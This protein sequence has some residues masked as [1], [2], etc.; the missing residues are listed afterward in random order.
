MAHSDDLDFVQ[1][2]LAGSRMKLILYLI[3]PQA[4]V[5]SKV[6]WIRPTAVLAL[7]MMSALMITRKAKGFL[8]DIWWTEASLE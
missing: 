2:G 5:E 3:L 8:K 6:K 7:P 1:P 4:A